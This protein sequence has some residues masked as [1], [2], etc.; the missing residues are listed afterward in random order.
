MAIDPTA[1]IHP[2]SVIEPGAQIGAGV[3]IGPFCVVGP[4]V[5]LADRVELKSHVVVAGDTS[6]GEDTVIFSF[7]TIGEI[8]QD[9]KFDGEK[10]RLEVGKRNRIR[11]G[12]TMNTGTVQGGGLTRLGNDN[13][14]MAYTHL[15]HDCLV[16]NH[17]TFANN[18]QTNRCTS[19]HLIKW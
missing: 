13:W 9:L 3:R 4:D 11:E 16:G 12:V 10:T 8:P 17:C 14:L 15:A 6:V 2:S 18:T 19:L 1:T 7:A 5:R